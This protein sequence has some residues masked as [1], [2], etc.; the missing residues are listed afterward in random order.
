[1]IAAPLS[2]FGRW[3]TG[4]NPSSEDIKPRAGRAPRLLIR[5]LNACDA[6]QRT[7]PASTYNEGYRR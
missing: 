6:G 3:Q 2:P 4:R 5:S 7:R 1:M